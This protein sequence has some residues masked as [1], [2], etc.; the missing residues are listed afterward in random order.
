VRRLVAVG[1]MNGVPIY[2]HWTLLTGVGLL[3]L[4]SLGSLANAA[5][6][7]VAIVAYFSAMLLH[8]WGHVVLARRRGCQVFGIQLYPLVGLTKFQHPHT[9]LDHCVIAWGGVLF[10]T[11]VGLP[12]LVW[13]VAV[14]YSRLEVLNAFMAMFAYLTVIMVPVNLAPVA[15]LDGAIA[16]SIIPI[17]LRRLKGKKVPAGAS[18]WNGL[19]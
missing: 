19:G 18:R 12:M 15:P 6:S 16:W 10:Q 17:F 7:A 14:G 13:I 11:A 4:G 9:R 2:V 1:T 8:E 3:L 5:A